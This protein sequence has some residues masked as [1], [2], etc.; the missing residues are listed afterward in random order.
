[1]PRPIRPGV[2]KLTGLDVPREATLARDLTDEA[3]FH[4]EE[5]T[6][7][8]IAAG[9]SPEDATARARAQYG[10]FDEASRDIQQYAKRRHRRVSL[11]FFIDSVLQDTRF[12][13]R[14]LARQPGWT[15]VAV[16]ALALGIG[17]SA[18]VFSVVDD[19]L[20]DPL[21][22]PHADRVVLVSLNHAKS[23]ITISPEYEQLEQWSHARSFESLHGISMSDATQAGDG[24]PRTLRTAMAD[25]GFFAFAAARIRAGRG[26]RP[27]E[28]GSGAS[29]AGAPVV[30]LSE[31]L[32]RARYDGDASAIGRTMTLDGKVLTI[33]GV[34]ADGLRM[35]SYTGDMPDVWLPPSQ[36]GR[37]SAPIIGRLRVGAT[38]A[39]AQAELKSISDR[40][41]R[42]RPPVGMVFDPVVIAPGSTGQVR[43]S[44]LL[45]AGAVALLLLI[46]CSNVAHLLL[47]RG[48]TREREIAVRAALGAG[49]ARIVRQLV[50]ESLLLAA[51]GCVAGL[52]VGMGA[53]RLIVDLR[54]QSMG[55]LRSV[56]ID[57]RV[58]A[59]TIALSVLTGLAFGVLSASDGVRGGRFTA[60]RVAG[61]AATDRRRRRM[62]T[63]LV[64]SEMALS[65]VLLVGATLLVRT[66]MNLHAVDP[67][68][69][70]TGLYSVSIQ[71]PMG[72]Y[73][74]EADRQAYAA[75]LLD[76]ARATPEL[77]QAT[78]AA[79]APPRTGVSVG[80]WE[81]E[82]GVQANATTSGNAITATNTVRA[83][84]FALLRMR[85]LSG[86]TFDDGSAARRE[87]VISEEL[88]RQLWGRA[89]V[90]GEQFRM[91]A[92]ASSHATPQPWY[93]VR[94]V[95]ANAAMLSLV[96]DRRTPAFYQTSEHV[97]GYGGV[98]LIVRT[99]DGRSPTAAVRKVLLGLDPSLSPVP[100]VS[101]SESLMKSVS[102]QRFMMTLLTAFAIVAIAL[103]AI[104]LYGVIAFMVSQRTREIGVRVALG[105]EVGDIRRLVLGRGLAL[106][107]AGLVLGVGGAAA[108]ARV[109]RGTLYGVT[110]TD[111]VSYA[112]GALALL[113]IAALACIAP[114]RR[115][116]R[117][118][119]VRAMR[120]E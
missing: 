55:T 80:R 4:I 43:R 20:V 64:V 87:V 35:P 62:R 29:G 44:V 99:R 42:D 116:V 69:D 102:G 93:V 59:V 67:G 52:A 73:P 63:L 114:M 53:L 76:A 77:G 11:S 109:L 1:M 58:V 18:A 75:R 8:L 106:A 47:A 24:D 97:A 51:A 82:R 94:G 14:A 40:V 13:L 111:P 25:S 65:V 115:A 15:A 89:N 71:L 31:S 6:A 84:Y 3:R 10:S 17:A 38:L 70:A 21:R 101:I 23:G 79:G 45:L 119:P 95:V 68:F 81:A 90:V 5:R 120:A 56:S 108:G 41:D 27:D 26:F 72:R 92:P 112:V 48:A 117:I 30:L 36:M 103:S 32:W 98:T 107:A 85:F 33:I 12:A 37:L 78:I 7:Q 49:R 54:P 46:A 100:P 16:L 61:D 50:T 39:A 105:A 19:L 113:G 57:G 104:G 22:Y 60:L 88:A 118:D 83:E 86:S 2:R 96:E 34:I 91:S 74:K 9:L 66:M 28:N 110:P